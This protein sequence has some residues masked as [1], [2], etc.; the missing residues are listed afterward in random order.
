MILSYS[1]ILDAMRITHIC[2]CGTYNQDWNYQDNLLAR[3]NK[4]DGND[5]LVVATCNVNDKESNRFIKVPQ[6]SFTDSYGVECVRIPDAPLIPSFI[7]EKLHYHPALYRILADRRP[8]IVMVHGIPSFDIFAV[9][10]YKRENP[11]VRLFADTH[12]SLDNSGRNWLSKKILHGLLNKTLIR[13]QKRYFEK[14]FY[15]A[16]ECGDFLTEVYGLDKKRDNMEFLTLGGIIPTPEKYRENRESIR[17]K[18]GIGER[19]AVFLHTGK[20][21]PAK[22]TLETLKMFSEQKQSILWVAGAF[23]KEIK[24]EAESII[25]ESPN[26]K[27]LGWLDGNEL[28]RYMCAADVLF[29]PGT[30]SASFQQAI[31]CSMVVFLGAY[32]NNEFLVSNGNGFI[33]KDVSQ[34]AD[35]VR[36]LTENFNMLSEMKRRSLEFAERE[37]SYKVLAARLY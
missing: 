29:Q 1:F 33:V 9:A 24:H 4:I 10:K 31:C 37:L 16:E 8:E 28:T 14:I 26:I 13:F 2:L 12:A 27:Y 22:K 5:V 18:M 3:Q 21:N 11:S 17:R 32:K 36:M 7:Q 19:D 6:S 35:K 23:S 34:A 30:Q 20:M 25:S 15:V